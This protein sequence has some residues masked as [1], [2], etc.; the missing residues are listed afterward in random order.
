MLN[1]APLFTSE[2]SEGIEQDKGSDYSMLATHIR[3]VVLPSFELNETSE[4]RNN[5][6]ELVQ[7][8]LLN[9]RTEAKRKQ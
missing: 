7:S 3:S 8:M 4:Q 5:R 2:A 6:L 1:W 9:K